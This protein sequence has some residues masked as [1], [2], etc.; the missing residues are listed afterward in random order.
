MTTKVKRLP[1]YQSVVILLTLGFSLVALI[2]S[3]SAQ[4]IWGIEPC[5]L[6]KLQ[7]VPYFFV[8]MFSGLAFWP[9]LQKISI[10]LIQVTFLVSLGLACYHLLVISGIVADPCS[11]PN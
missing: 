2:L 11:V 6:C 4:Y 5:K 7:R 9:N 3:Y 8:L 1:S 10:R